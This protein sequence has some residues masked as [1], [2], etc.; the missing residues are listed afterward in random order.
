MFHSQCFSRRVSCPRPG[1]ACGPSS[2]VCGWSCGA[3]PHGVSAAGPGPMGS[4]LWGLVSM[5]LKLWG[6][7]L[8]FGVWSHGVSAL[9][10][11]PMGSVLW[12]LVPWGRSCGALSYGAS[13]VC[14]LPPP[15]HP[16]PSSSPPPAR[17]PPRANSGGPGCPSS[18]ISVWG[19]RLGATDKPRACPHRPPQRLVPSPSPCSTV[20]PPRHGALS[21]VPMCQ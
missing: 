3:W 14:P 19:P 2:V 10:P 13:S 16:A 18:P 21:P 7:V 1:C 6:L 17:S 12:G 4:A 8:C 20:S 11:G 15:S 5:G 9:G